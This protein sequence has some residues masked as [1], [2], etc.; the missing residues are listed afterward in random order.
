MSKEAFNRQKFIQLYRSKLQNDLDNM[1][2]PGDPKMDA[3]NNPPLIIDAG[4]KLP[5]LNRDDASRT[6]VK[7]S[8]Q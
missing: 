2:Y 4:S 6:K 5:D 1:G 7:V 3:G 8:H